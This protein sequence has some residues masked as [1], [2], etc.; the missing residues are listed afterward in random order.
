MFLN[1]REFS[2]VQTASQCDAASLYICRLLVETDVFQ[3]T[4]VAAVLT[5][6]QFNCQ[7]NIVLGVSIFQCIFIAD[8]TREVQITQRLV[9]SNH[10]QIFRILHDLFQ[11]F[12]F[13]L[14][15]NISY[16]WGSDQN[17][18]SRRLFPSFVGT[19]C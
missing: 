14:Q 15:Q 5:F 1:I 3:Y 19:S 17:F 8:Y 7:T 16:D 12:Q 10:T 6:C 18:K 9:E 13:T 4:V 11:T 2:F